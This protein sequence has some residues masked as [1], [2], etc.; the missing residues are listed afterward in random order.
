MTGIR[1]YEA[2]LTLFAVV[3]ELAGIV[4][5]IGPNHPSKTVHLVLQDLTF[6]NCSTINNVPSDTVDV[7]VKIHLPAKVSIFF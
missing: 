1:F 7:I 5:A 2:T 3:K 6:V 4:V